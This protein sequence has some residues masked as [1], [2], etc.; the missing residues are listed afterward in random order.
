MK[1][2]DVEDLHEN[3]RVNVICQH[4]VVLI[5]ATTCSTAPVQFI[6]VQS[7]PFS[8][9]LH[10]SLL[11]SGSMTRVLQ[12]FDMSC[13]NDLITDFATSSTSAFIRVY[14]SSMC[15]R[16]SE[17]E[18]HCHLRSAARGDVVVP[19][20]TNKMHGPCSFAV[21]SP[22]VWN[23]LLLVARDSELTLPALHKL[24]KTELFRRAF[25]MP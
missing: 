13:N 25:S 5:T 4:L 1:V 23:L 22:A 9:P 24:L 19:R 15:I 3:W 21:S 7:S 16:V 17:I 20:T 12:Q 10:A 11:K 2:K 14:I 18:G 8:T 6:F